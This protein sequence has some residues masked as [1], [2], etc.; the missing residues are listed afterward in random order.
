MFG[1]FYKNKK[2]KRRANSFDDG[3]DSRLQSRNE[4]SLVDSKAP[5]VEWLPSSGSEGEK[6]DGDV[7][8][9]LG[10]LRDQDGRIIDTS[11]ILNMTGVRELRHLERAREQLAVKTK[12][13]PG[14]E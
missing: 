7:D 11:E 1:I 8:G 14:N 9:R 12:K 4:G 6:R 2:L 10:S 5:S 3:A 13:E